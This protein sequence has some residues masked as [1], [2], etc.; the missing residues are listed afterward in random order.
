MSRPG[1]PES[2]VT[3]ARVATRARQDGA[4]LGV[5]LEVLPPVVEPL[6]VLS[7]ATS[8]TGCMDVEL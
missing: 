2:A 1:D 6:G 4:A 7:V 3:P 8:T 5:L